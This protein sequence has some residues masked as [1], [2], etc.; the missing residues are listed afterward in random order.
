[1]F[2]GG[3]VLVRSFDPLLLRATS[4]VAGNPMIGLSSLR[5]PVRPKNS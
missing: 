2:L 4:L 1:M 3:R 5:D